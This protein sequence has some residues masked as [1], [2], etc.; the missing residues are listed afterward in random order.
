MS[1]RFLMEMEEQIEQAGRSKQSFINFINDIEI[2]QVK[3]WVEKWL[4]EYWT[5]E[6]SEVFFN[7][8]WNG[9]FD[10]TTLYT[11]DGEEL[12]S[13]LDDIEKCICECEK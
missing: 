5:D 11:G 7:T 8:Y 6:M 9:S 10:V 4:E 12:P 3:P 13:L 1:V 2:T